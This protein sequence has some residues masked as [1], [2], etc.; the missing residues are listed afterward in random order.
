MTRVQ[1]LSVRIVLV[2]LDIGGVVVHRGRADREPAVRA[3]GRWPPSPT[4]R[5]PV[6]EERQQ[7][8]TEDLPVDAEALR[9]EVRTKYREVALDPR[10]EHHFHTG[11]FLARHL[12]YDDRWVDPLPEEAVESFAGIANP[13]ALRPL[14]PGER[15]VDIGS[16]AG[17]DT[18]VAAA[19]VGDEGQVVGVDMTP[20]MLEKSR[21]NAELLGVENVEFREGLAE[22]LPSTTGGPTS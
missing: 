2:A 18:F 9:A 4:Q 6:P 20:E 22:E 11:R 12:G 13:F 3:T 7:D 1:D 8:V 15:V 10:G 5:L 16:G 14:A 19:Q 21:R 17:F